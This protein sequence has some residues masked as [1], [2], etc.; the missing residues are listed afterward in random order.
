M[1]SKDVCKKCINTNK[2]FAVGNWGHSDESR[3]EDGYV[4]CPVKDGGVWYRCYV[5]AGI[6]KWCTFGME[7]GVSVVM[8]EHE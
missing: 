1:L 6:R 8:G 2:G 4:H 3:W 5:S 7:H